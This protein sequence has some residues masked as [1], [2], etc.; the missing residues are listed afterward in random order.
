MGGPVDHET[1]DRLA[2]LNPDVVLEQFL[3]ARAKTADTELSYR[4]DMGNFFAWADAVGLHPLTVSPSDL[5]R[6]I[7][8]LGAHP[9]W[10]DNTKYRA[11]STLRSFFS[12]VADRWAI[13]SPMDHRDV[14]PNPAAGR[15]SP[16]DPP[17]YLP[18]EVF[19]QVMSAVFEH[20]APPAAAAL[21]LVGINGLKPAEV[22][23]A[24]VE[25]LVESG[26]GLLLRLRTRSEEAI[27]PLTGMVAELVADCARGRAAGPLI[28][29]QGGNRMNGTNLRDAAAKL[30]RVVGLDH[31]S[32]QLLRNTAG[33]VALMSGPP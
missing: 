23:A 19:R 4:R 10:A 21:G 27:T 2:A 11:Y 1:Y 16:D 9:D 33:V 24:N 18:P 15:P 17:P 26:G 22:Q 31:L 32:V 29:N 25:D 7:R 13:R 14:L 28:L 3:E 6:F 12:F 20:L 8:E 5:N 30:R